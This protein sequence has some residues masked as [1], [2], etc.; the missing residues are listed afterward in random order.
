MITL[1]VDVI[2]PLPLPSLY[3]YRLPFDLNEFAK[4]GSRVVVQFG[5]KKILTAII[6]CIHEKPPVIYQAKSVLSLLDETPVLSSIQLEFYQWIAQYY[7]CHIGE[8]INAGLPSGLKISNE[9]KIQYNPNFKYDIELTEKEKALLEE[10]HKNDSVTYSE[11]AE[12]LQ[13]KSV[14]LIISSLIKKNAVI[15]FEEIKE[16]YK[17]KIIRKIRLSTKYANDLISLKYLISSLESKPKQ[18]EYLLAYLGEVPVFQVHDL[19]ENGVEKT[20][21]ITSENKSTA[22]NTLIKNGIFEEFEVIISRIDTN[23]NAKIVENFTLSEHQNTAKNKIIELFRTKEIVLLHGVT[24]SGKT[25]VYIDLIKQVILN[26]SQVLFLLPEIALTT[27]IV[28]RLRLVFGNVLGVYH[29]KYS[30]NERVEVWQKI[31]TGELKIII[32]VRSSI[33]LPFNNLGLIIIDEEHDAS[34]KQYDPPPR[35]HA[36]DA[37][38]VLAQKHHAKVLLGSATPAIETYHNATSGKFGLVTL[39]K[40]YGTAQMPEILL[41]DL[42]KEKQIKGEFSHQLFNEIESTIERK[43]QVI[44]FQNRRGY[45]P[46]LTCLDC[47]FVPHCN[48]CSVS[49]TY[50][51]YKQELSCHYCGHHQV[52]PNLCPACGSSKIKPIGFGTEKLEEDVQL[53]LPN[54][55]VKRMDLDT[56]RKKNGYQSIIS[57][58]ENEEI[59]ILVGTQMVTKGLDFDNVSLVGVFDIDRM[60]YFPDFRSTERVFQIATQVSGR[61]GR[62]DKK[63]KVIIQTSSPTH[64]I[65]DKI[66]QNDYLGLYNQEILEREKFNYPPY[67]R[68]IKITLKHVDKDTVAQAAMKLV[69]NMYIFLGNARVLGPEPPAINKI[70]N[71]YLQDIYI[72]IEKGN[73]D[74][75]KIKQI[76]KDCILTL[77]V[78]KPY[79]SILVA[80]DVDVI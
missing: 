45:A 54:A 12:L 27:Q 47:G 74:I 7:M 16:K 67:S 56:T 69:E 38:M 19:N 29:S 2:L 42:K 79:R 32:G 46:F 1:F 20:K 68:L 73:I 14:Y 11:A 40:R 37:A 65:F 71:Y 53:M 50:H 55:R 9:S 60:I 77:C 6:G 3:T 57:A 36:R 44:L 5:Q 33:F 31:V 15:L 25:E 58:I 4:V 49:L 39:D 21:I 43:E 78:T 22:L 63:G 30:D 70:R 59:D 24:G 75:R 13:V 61:A 64:P 51:L 62:K 80:I 35:Y 41:V 23:S 52:V 66:I 34:Y 8:V 17:P 72:K 18:L 10:L 48:N 28:S 76:L 26:E